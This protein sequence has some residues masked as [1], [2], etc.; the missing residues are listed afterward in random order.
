MMPS[1]MDRLR[2]A[3]RDRIEATATLATRI[4]EVPAPTGSELER[5]KLVASLWQE[6]GYQTEIDDMSNVHVRR[7][8]HNTGPVLL[9]LAHLDTVFPFSIPISVQ[10]NGDTLH[11]PGIGDNS[12]SVA[13]LLSL[14]ELLDSLKQATA[15][16]IV[17]VAN[18]GEEGLGNLR[19]ARAAVERYRSQLGAVIAVD[20]ELGHIT[21]VAVG[22]KRW[23]ISASGQGGHSFHDFGRPSAIHGLAR[24]IT[25]IADISVPHEP[26]T[27][28]NVGIVEGGTSVNTIAAHAEAILDMRSTDPAALDR[29]AEQVQT[30]V[31]AGAKADLKTEIEVL[32]ERPAGRRDQFDPLVQ[33]ATQTLHWLD[34]GSTYE[35]A[36]TDANIP[37]SMNIPA[38]TIGITH[39][40]G[41]HTTEEFLYIPPIG[42]GLAQL[43]RLTVDTCDWLA[44]QA[45]RTTS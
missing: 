19:G 21:H 15:I 13:S 43:A 44:Q 38:V 4:C 1:D 42:D 40:Q 6:R 34:I 14:F 35:A 39:A 16:D 12:V 17:A 33:L 3:A 9:L 30:I 25:S 23:R 27:T 7:G 37:I 22:S 24:I 8:Q 5:A 41:A 11:G 36:S 20:G 29:L 28:Y 10:R 45:G 32:G 26:P 18:V 31:E 2:T